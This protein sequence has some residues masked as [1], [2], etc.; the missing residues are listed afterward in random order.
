MR[1]AEHF[2]PLGRLGEGMN[3]VRG[4]DPQ[5]VLGE[6]EKPVRLDEDGGLSGREISCVPKGL[7]G[8][9]GVGTA[10]GRIALFR[11]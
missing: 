11:E 5:A 3:G 1:R 10:E 7:K 8:G 2:H 9:E 4:G 6:A